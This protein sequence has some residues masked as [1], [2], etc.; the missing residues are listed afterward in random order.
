MN[1]LILSFLSLFLL[2]SC[3]QQPTIIL[4]KANSSNTCKNY[5]SRLD[6]TL[7]WVFIDAY[8]L[9][10]RELSRALEDADGIIMTGGADIHP[11]RYEAGFDTIRCGV[12]DE[13]R[14]E[15]EY[16]L[17]SHVEETHI[18]CVGFCR[19][20]QIMNIYNGGSLHPHLPDTISDMHRS[21]GGATSHDIIVLKSQ[22][23]LPYKV[24]SHWRVV[25]HHHQGISQLGDDL[26][27]WAISPDGLYEGIRHS[28]TL[29]YPYY[30]GVQWHPERS[31]PG[32]TNDDL[33]GNSFINAV[34]KGL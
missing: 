31:N 9:S 15:L 34:K 14:D 4:S 30:V 24:G 33:I 6:T 21:D 1:K 22:E 17:L 32:F 23:V 11:D 13:F 10:E 16:K 20:L 5:L 8:T 26:E 25:S 7:D 2:A 12:I 29:T 28:D 3:T 19:G 18:P 27:V